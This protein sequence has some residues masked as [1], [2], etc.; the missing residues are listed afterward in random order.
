M[1]GSLDVTLRI[2]LVGL[3]VAWVQSLRFMLRSFGGDQRLAMLGAL[4]FWNRALVLG[5]LRSRSIPRIA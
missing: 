2:V 3:A 4:L 5:F 1:T